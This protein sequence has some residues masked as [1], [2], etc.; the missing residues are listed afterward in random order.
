MRQRTGLFFTGLVWLALSVPTLGWPKDD[1]PHWGYD[2]EFGPEH[3]AE[4][5]EEY[6][7]CTGENSQSPIDLPGPERIARMGLQPADLGASIR[8]VPASTPQR[9]V[10]NG[11]TVQIDYPGGDE[12]RLGDET[13]LLLQVH[14][15][16]PSEHTIDGQHYP[17]EF[18]F[19]HQNKTGDLA[20]LGLL[21][22]E[23]RKDLVFQQIADRIPA[24]TGAEISG[25]GLEMPSGELLPEDLVVFRYQGSL[26]TPPCSEGIRWLVAAEPIEMSADQIARFTSVYDHN[27]RPVQPPRGRS[28]S[29]ERISTV[30]RLKK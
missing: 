1:A 3:W 11:H 19:V 12:L 13:F 20:V 6:A 17:L 5:S 30:N 10:N 23:G 4:V 14:F 24:E 28:L 26:T 16:S 22:K 25:H 18:H 2:K 29:L 8:L 7:A 21:V 27:Y 9:I 15:H